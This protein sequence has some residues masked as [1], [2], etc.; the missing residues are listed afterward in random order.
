MFALMRLVVL[1]SKQRLVA[2]MGHAPSVDASPR[3]LETGV[4]RVFAASLLRPI[5]AFKQ[6]ILSYVRGHQKQLRSCCSR[7][8]ATNS[9]T[10]R[11]LL[12]HL[13]QA[14]PAVSKCKWKEDGW[15]FQMHPASSSLAGLHGRPRRPLPPQHPSRSKQDIRCCVLH[16]N[17]QARR[18]TTRA[19]SRL[20]CS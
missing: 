4:P 5:V 3:W 16:P 7:C 8:Q 12:L 13:P 20:D 11:E 14:A 17:H 6:S 9:Y 18:P 2:P 15:K 1:A 10:H 19:F